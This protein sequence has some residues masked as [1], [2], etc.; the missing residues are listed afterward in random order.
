MTNRTKP[1][2]RALICRPHVWFVSV[3]QIHLVCCCHYFLCG[4]KKNSLSDL[5]HF[6][7]W[8]RMGTSSFLPE[9]EK[10]REKKQHKDGDKH[11]WVAHLQKKHLNW[12]MSLIDMK[13]V[14]LTASSN[15][16]CSFCVERK[17]QKGWMCLYWLVGRTENGEHEVGLNNWQ[18]SLITRLVPEE[19]PC[20]LL[21]WL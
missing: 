13:N 19:S 11:G 12:H 5:E 1:G 3:I 9:P 14:K 2:W 8:L 18:F 6:R 17:W 21:N 7:G 4:W 20:C 16:Y 15:C 10:W